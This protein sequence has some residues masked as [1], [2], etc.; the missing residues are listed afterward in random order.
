M[1]EWSPSHHFSS[2]STVSGKIVFSTFQTSLKFQ[3]SYMQAYNCNPYEECTRK[4]FGACIK[5]ETRYNTCHR[6]VYNPASHI[7][8]LQKTYNLRPHFHISYEY[9]GL[10]QGAVDGNDY[11][12]IFIDGVQQAHLG[13]TS[14]K[15]VHKILNLEHHSHTLHIKI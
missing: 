2:T 11:I 7:H 4:I 15:H 14:N 10:F 5:K 3:N 1:T 12:K 8:T 13:P 9:K 6:R